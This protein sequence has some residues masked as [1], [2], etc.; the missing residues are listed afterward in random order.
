MNF[1]DNLYLLQTLETVQGEGDLIGKPSVLIR[2]AGCNCRCP[3]CDTEWSWN[4][5][6]AELITP[7]EFDDWWENIISKYEHIPNLMITGGEPL[8]YKN[9]NMFLKMI[10]SDKFDSIEIETNGSLLNSDFIKNLH[11]NVKLNISPKLN[12]TWYLDK[13]N[14]DY[15]SLYPIIA[16]IKRHNN[17]IFKFVNDP[18]YAG[19]V[20]AFI[21]DQKLNLNK[22]YIMPLSPNRKSYSKSDFEKLIRKAS[23]ETVRLCIDKGY[24]YSTRLHLYLWDDEQEIID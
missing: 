21:N 1:N 5:D 6:R 11:P 8:L 7:E 3:W 13:Y 16:E 4:D 10:S 24:N 2:F 18:K 9:N 17:Y 12:S 14:V 23:L 19:M 22:V 15:T 20:E